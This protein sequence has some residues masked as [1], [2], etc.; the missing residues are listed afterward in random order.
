MKDHDI[1]IRHSA[2]RYVPILTVDD[3][4]FY[5]GERRKTAAEALAYAEYQVKEL[6]EAGDL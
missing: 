4:E 1:I 6:A 3:K 5:R 2:G